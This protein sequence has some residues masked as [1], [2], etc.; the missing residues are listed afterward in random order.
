MLTHLGLFYAYW[1]VNCSYC[2]F[3]FTFFVKQIFKSFFVHS[4]IEYKWFLNGSI[5]PIDGALTG[6]ILL[7]QSNPWSNGN[8]EVLNTLQISKT[9][10]SPSD[11]VQCHTQDTPLQGIQSTFSCDYHLF[12]RKEDFKNCKIKD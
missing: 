11:A 12:D 10:T 6:T 8:E 3:I 1:L 5:L 4:F 9:G 2:M 7:R